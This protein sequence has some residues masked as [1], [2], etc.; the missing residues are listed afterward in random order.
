MGTDVH[1]DVLLA[2]IEGTIE[3]H[4]KLTPMRLVQGEGL[5]GESTSCR[6]LY[7]S[8]THAH[9]DSIGTDAHQDVLLAVIEGPIRFLLPSPHRLQSTLPGLEGDGQR[10]LP[11]PS[12]L[13]GKFSD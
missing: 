7:G 9:V 5:L 10:G 6:C 12:D 13:G 4:V 8:F 3:A 2:V 11:H 1:Q